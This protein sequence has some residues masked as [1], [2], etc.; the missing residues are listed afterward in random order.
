M[1]KFWISWSA[2]EYL[3]YFENN[4]RNNKHYVSNLQ[5]RKKKRIRIFY[6]VFK[7]ILIYMT[8]NV[9]HIYCFVSKKQKI[10]VKV[11]KKYLLYIL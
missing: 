10:F 3:H 6:E 8:N 11:F 1:E 4:M 7:K 5:V 9:Q 2:C